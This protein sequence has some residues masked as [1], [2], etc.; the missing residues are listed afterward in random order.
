MPKK[1]LYNHFQRFSEEYYIAYNARSGAVALMTPENYEVYESLLDK[2]E[3]GLEDLS[4]EERKLLKQLE[5]GKF[6]CPDDYDELAA[7]KFEHNIGR[8]NI[9]ELGLVIAPTMACN[10]ACEYCYEQNKSGRM[11]P[12]IVESLVEFVKKRAKALGSLSVTWYG[13]EPLLAMDIIEDLSSRFIEFS[14]EYQFHYT[15]SIVTNGYLLTPQT[16]DRLRELKVV[17]GQVTLDG[18]AEQHNTKRP[19]K[20]GKDSFSTIIEN[21]KYAM[22]RLGIS[23]RVNIDKSFSAQTIQQLLT[24]LKQA[25][26][27]ERVPINFGHLEA[28]T[29]V[30][31]NIAEACYDN[32]NFSAV[33]TD[34]YRL[35]LANGFMIQ[36]IPSPT[37][38]CCMAQIVNSFVV[39]PLGDLYRCWNYVGNR[40]RCMG[41]IKDEIDF[42]HANFRRLFKVDP[43]E[44]ETCRS[45]NLLPICMGGCPSRRAD[46]GLSGEQ[47]CESWKYNL[48]PMLEIIAASKQQEM[49]RSAKEQS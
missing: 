42:Q 25:G 44:E 18:P 13:G 5:Y 33:E 43:F 45:C 41:N 21:L 9:S 6:V 36:K 46:R 35:L 47:V 40:E 15:A 4:D 1:S 38:V 3:N 26:L 8:Y 29:E 17:G 31:A 14:K 48:E 11:Q 19:L 23:I 20:N 2:F 30:C 34:Y 49:A 37:P 10:M 27:H 12:E 22:T 16:V 7:I 32:T 28:S 24:E 39:D